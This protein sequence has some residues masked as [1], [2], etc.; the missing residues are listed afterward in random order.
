[1]KFSQYF[2]PVLSKFSFAERGD[3]LESK[4]REETI[5]IPVFH[6]H[7][8]SNIQAFIGN[9]ICEII[10]LITAH[11]FTPLFL[12]DILPPLELRSRL[13]VNF[14]IHDDFSSEDVI[15]AIFH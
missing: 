6:F 15:T 14:M 1:M 9:F 8:L 5:F 4:K 10:F 13:N 3:S 11:I 7:P 2:M 12:Y